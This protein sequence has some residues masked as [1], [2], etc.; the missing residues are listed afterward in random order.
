[1]SINAAFVSMR[2]GAHF[3]AYP[4]RYFIELMIIGLITFQI[5]FMSDFAG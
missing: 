5:A 2:I 1:M 4:L 3:E